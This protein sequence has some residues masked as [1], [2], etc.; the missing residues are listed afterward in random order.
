MLYV[1]TWQMKVDI[2]RIRFYKIF[3]QYAAK[4]QCLVKFLAI[5]QLAIQNSMQMQF[6]NHENSKQIENI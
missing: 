2:L 3:S 6:A 4:I 1:L 5:F